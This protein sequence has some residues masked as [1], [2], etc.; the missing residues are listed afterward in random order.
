MRVRNNVFYSLF[1]M[2]ADLFVLAVAFVIAYIV[3]VQFDD[4]PL[5]AQITANDFF[6]TFMS[7]APFWIITLGA[8]GLYD[9]NIRNKRTNETLKLLV[10]SFIGILLIIGMS[11]L[12]ATGFSS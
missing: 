8:L 10:G 5:V 12:W 9:R 2:I 4:R 3:R 6:L 11:L 7:I 1:L